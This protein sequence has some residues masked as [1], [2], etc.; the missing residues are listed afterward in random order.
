MQ[1]ARYTR[2]WKA[3]VWS[4]L[5]FYTILLPAFL[6]LSYSQTAYNCTSALNSVYRV[7]WAVNHG[8]GVCVWVCVCVCVCVVVVWGGG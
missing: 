4:H 7:S 8:G 3:H 2:A 5:P 6:E 1:P